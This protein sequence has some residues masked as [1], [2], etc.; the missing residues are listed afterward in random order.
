MRIF[1]VLVVALGLLVP[2]EAVAQE[3]GQG[4]LYMNRLPDS[5]VRG[6]TQHAGLFVYTMEGEPIHSGEGAG[7]WLA[8]SEVVLDEGWYLIEVGQTRQAANVRK[9]FVS[10]GEATVV[11]TGWVAVET[12][13]LDDQPRIGCDN[14]FGRLDVYIRNAEGQEVEIINNGNTGIRDRGMVQVPIGEVIVY[15]HDIAVTVDVRE[16]E[17]YE[18]PVGFQ[19]PISGRRPTLSVGGEADEDSVRI[20][21]CEDGPLH[22]PAGTYWA[23]SIVDISVA[24]FEA[25]Q[26]TQVEVPAEGE[27]G[28]SDLR[29]DETRHDVYE[30]EGSAPVVPSPEELS[31]IDFGAS[32][33]SGVRLGG[34]GR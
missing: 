18:I 8:G 29:V 24:P 23:S 25:R 28:Y 13:E 21:M 31:R 16:D 14:W 26:W 34:F 30:G 9:V 12:V 5:R 3:D 27:Q 2:L 19:Q 32:G 7:A 11:P 22:V 33:G 4:L 20:S 6:G 10:A 17:V 1:A 15:F